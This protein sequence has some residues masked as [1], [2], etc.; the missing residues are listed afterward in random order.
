MQ[1]ARR[2][3]VH[4]VVRASAVQTATLARARRITAL[5]IIAVLASASRGDDGRRGPT[6]VPVRTSQPTSIIEVLEPI[7]R[8]QRVP[9][10]A[11]AVVNDAGMIAQGA[12]GRRKVRSKVRVELNDPFHLGSCTKSMTATLCAIL[13]D[14]KVIRWT[15]TVAET[16]PEL[17]GSLHA[18]FRNVTL[19]QLLCHRAGLP[20]D[21]SPDLAIFPRLRV[22][23]GSLPEQRAKLVALALSRAP[24]FRPGSK[25]AYSNYGFAIA[26]AMAERAAGR[27]YEE[28][29]RQRVF[30][31][32]GMSSAGFGSPGSAERLDAPWGHL[33]MLGLLTA[34]SP[35]PLADNPPAIAPAGTVHASIGDWARYASFHLAGARGQ[36]RLLSRASF[37]KLHADNHGQEYAFG[38]VIR[39]D[40]WAR[41]RLLAHDGSNTMWYAVIVLAPE[42]NV[43][44]VIACN[45]GTQSGAK[46]C[47]Q[48][49]LALRER[50][51]ASP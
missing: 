40:G 10:L 46:A 31:P 5:M 23:A 4:P 1:I 51:T 39:K 18:D 43:G 17:A 29:M 49:Y 15:T 27:A 36:A 24:A 2:E 26:G 8:R 16:F 45:A 50:F 12:T 22:M 32:L 34:Q 6:T 20:N 14:R 44:F 33:S 25:F 35:G 42:R 13:V 48:A 38:W 41:G 9:A 47:R 11:A 28:L 30:A 3:T 21:H 7:R 37:E 19:E